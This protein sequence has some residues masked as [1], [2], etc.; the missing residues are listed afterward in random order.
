[1]TEIAIVDDH[2]LLG[3][4][5]ANDLRGDGLA[6]T[7]LP[8]GPDLLERVFATRPEILL[9]DLELGPGMPQGVELVRPISAAGIAVVVLTGVDSKLMWARCLEEGAVG[10][11]SKS[12]DFDQL[13]TQVRAC[14]AS[15]EI[16]PSVSDRLELLQ[17]LMAH[18]REHQ[19]RVQ[20]FQAL[21]KREAVVLERIMAG[22]SVE[23]ISSI[24][25]VAVSTV[26][27]HIKAILRKLDVHSQLQAIALAHQ[28]GWPYAVQGAD[29]RR[30]PGGRFAS[31]SCPS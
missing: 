31:G 11:L 29:R 23:D 1:M 2:V 24:D 19:D 14:V 27:T 8:V 28:A 5:L 26:R 22:L 21:T 6:A 25:S 7:Y 20:P 18:R 12:M 10:V 17:S 3:Q 4:V 9:L 30:S 15:G 13:V 16:L